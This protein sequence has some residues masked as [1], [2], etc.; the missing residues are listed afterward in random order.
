MPLVLNSEVYTKIKSEMLQPSG[1]KSE[2]FPNESNTNVSTFS[3][4]VLKAHESHLNPQINPAKQNLGKAREKFILE[5][6]L[7]KLWQ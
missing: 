4:S 2:E 3:F 6:N 5:Q 7:D 1:T